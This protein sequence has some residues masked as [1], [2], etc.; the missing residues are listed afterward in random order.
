L[1]NEFGPIAFG[2]I[3]VRDAA[4]VATARAIVAITSFLVHVDMEA[5]FL[6]LAFTATNTETA[7]A[8]F[9]GNFET[10]RSRDD[11]RDFSF[12]IQFAMIFET[13]DYIGNGEP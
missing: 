8:A 10:G 5:S 4:H 2:A 13:V 7:H 11:A 3:D 12:V 1:A 9:V 6:F